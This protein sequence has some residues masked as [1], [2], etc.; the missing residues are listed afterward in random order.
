LRHCSSKLPWLNLGENGHGQMMK[1]LPSAYGVE[2]GEFAYSTV[3][4]SCV[5]AW[6]AVQVVDVAQV[7]DAVHGRFIAGGPIAIATEMS[8][9]IR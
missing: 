5:V 7:A 3:A 8:S 2:T 9:L 4:S 6:G 1:P